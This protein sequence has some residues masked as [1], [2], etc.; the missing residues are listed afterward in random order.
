MTTRKVCKVC[1]SAPAKIHGQCHECY[2]RLKTLRAENQHEE[3]VK[4]LTYRGYVVGLYKAGNGKLKARP[5]TRNAEHLPKSSTINLNMW[6]DGYTKDMVKSFK[7]C[8]LSLCAPSV[9]YVKEP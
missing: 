6:C 7:A 3:P 2:V 9:R 4:Y 5:E 8:V 1:F